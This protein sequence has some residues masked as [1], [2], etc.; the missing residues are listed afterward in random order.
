MKSKRMFK[1]EKADTRAEI[2]YGSVYESLGF[3]DHEDMA[4]KADLVIEIGKAIK[5]GKLT[6]AQA[7]DLFNISQPKVSDLLSAHFRGYPVERLMYFLNTLGKD[8]DIVVKSKPR[9]RKV[10][11]NV[12]P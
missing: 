10:R 8:V 7:A 11:V 4:T 1:E 9:N 5:K 2:S 6:Q 12:Y 3:E